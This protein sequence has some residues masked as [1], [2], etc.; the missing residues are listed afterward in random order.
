MTKPVT[1]IVGSTGRLGGLIVK[2]LLSN[3]KT[4]LRLLV[5]QG[6]EDKAKQYS[7]LGIEIIK[8]DL[9]S[10][11]PS[12]LQKA[13]E[14]ASTVVSA[15]IGDRDVTVDG[16][17]KLADAAQKSGVKLFI[18]S[19]F[20]ANFH[21]CDYGD[22]Y[23]FDQRKELSE[24]LKKTN[25]N[26]VSVLCGAFM[27]S[28]LRAFINFKD[29]TIP[30]YGSPDQPLQF[31]TYEDTAKMV[32]ELVESGQVTSGIYGFSAVDASPKQLKEVAEEVTGEEW[33]LVNKGSVQ[34]QFAMIQN[35]K[36]KNPNN[37]YSYLYEQY[38]YTMY[39][40]K[41]YIHEKHEP[42]NFEFTSLKDYLKKL[43]K[44]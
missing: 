13:C 25:I 17:K 4:D 30:Y 28:A 32:A 36:A 23:N 38:T 44:N 21:G 39:S 20:A 18:P 33:R 1:L 7:D 10:S 27:E 31:T 35:I 3:N 41:A 26:H 14:G 16:Q 6:S 42:K 8:G 12:D 43:N 5:R 40:G 22:N 9:V 24:Y 15:I 34:D 37:L 29:R 11:S 19:D 2:S